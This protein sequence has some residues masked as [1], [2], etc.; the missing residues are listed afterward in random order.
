MPDKSPNDDME[1]FRFSNNLSG[2]L[3]RETDRDDDEFLS[4][5]DDIPDKSPNDEKEEARFSNNLSGGLLRVSDRD[6]DDLLISSKSSWSNDD[7]ESFRPF[8][9]CRYDRFADIISI[10]L[11]YYCNEN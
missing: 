9:S 5:V 2:G 6:C 3:L 1:E 10:C 8:R 11:E 4:L 7:D